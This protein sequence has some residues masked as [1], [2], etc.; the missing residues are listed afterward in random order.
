[1]QALA[2][3]YDGAELGGLPLAQVEELSY[4]T[5]LVD[6]PR[7]Y[8]V[9]LQLNVDADV[10]DGDKSWQGRLVYTPSYNGAVIQGD[11]QCWDTL[12]GKW[13]ATGGP[14]A[15][16]ATVDNPQPLGTLLAQ[17]PNLGVHADYSVILLKAGDGWSNFQGEA[18]PVVLSIEGERS[19]LAFGT[20]AEQNAVLL[21]VV[22]QEP[23][24]TPTPNVDDKKN[25]EKE[26]PE[27][28]KPEKEKEK[29]EKEEKEKEVEKDRTFELGSFNWAD[30]DWENFDWDKVDWEHLDWSAFGI[31]ASN[32]ER[33]EALRAFIADVEQ[34]KEGGWEEM[35]FHSPGACVAYYIQQHTPDDLR[36]DFNW[37]DRDWSEFD[38][39]DSKWNGRND[40]DDGDNKRDHDNNRRRK[41]GDDN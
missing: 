22:Y 17:F 40:G 26:K 34:C 11:W 18:S 30:F 9:M 5:R 21:P 37:G 13:W 23:T 15:A 31:D 24:Q 3:E 32:N 6:G 19:R 39:N 12:V 28:E 2:L 16:Q 4:C 1:M 8:A 33:A 36:W 20:V 10:T 35:N 38:W 41:W 29:K 25:G 27:K 14:V 7:P